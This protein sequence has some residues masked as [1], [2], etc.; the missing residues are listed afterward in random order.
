MLQP[1]VRDLIPGRL[2]PRQRRQLLNDLELDLHAL[3]PDALDKDGD[4]V[5]GREALPRVGK[6]GQIGRQLDETAVLL[7]AAD[8]TP[9][10]LAGAEAAGVLHPGAQELP[11]GH[12]DPA[13][14][15]VYGPDRRQ[16]F[17]PCPEA[18]VGVR[19][20]GHGDVFDGQHGDDA[21]SDV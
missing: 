1:A 19:D 5:T 18:V 20:A 11:V 9:Y 14:L 2:R 15:P 6:T 21:A 12:G 3:R 16:N 4:A 17:L 10:R 13:R 7:H 8:R